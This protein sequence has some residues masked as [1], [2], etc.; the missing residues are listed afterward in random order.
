M[1]RLILC[2]SALFAIQDPPKPVEP[3]ATPPK[4]AAAGELVLNVQTLTRL[5][6]DG[7]T[8][9]ADY[10]TIPLAM[11][12][13]PTFVCF[14]MEGGSRAEF[15][16]IVKR[17]GEFACSTLAVDLRTGKS[18][19]GVENQTALSAAKVLSKAEF[20]NEEAFVDVVEALKW[21]REL[22][23]EN[24]IFALGSGTSAALVLAAAARDPAC[25]DAVFVF[26][27]GED[28][29]GWSIAMES[30]QIK[31]PVYITCDGSPQEAART[32]LIGNAIDKKL[33]TMVIP[34]PSAS[35]QRGASVLVQTDEALRDRHWSGVVRL[36][37]QLA[38]LSAEPAA[39]PKKD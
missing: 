34:T 39:A 29:P 28:V 33:R 4:A 8:L 19:G 30:K 23:P 2:L 11:V 6:P 25:A 14:H 31:V 27:P 18:T 13:R 10:H 16:P 35:V 37:L 21:A 15:A 38:P 9:T 17:L 1:I 20:K 5:L 24:K 7:V 12:T 22:S 26:S 3:P 36:I 32:R